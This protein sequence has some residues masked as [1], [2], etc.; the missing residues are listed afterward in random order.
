MLL[1]AGLL[2]GCEFLNDAFG[3]ADVF[4]AE[5]LEDAS[6]ETKDAA[7]P[8]EDETLS[9]PYK[10]FLHLNKIRANPV[11]Y[12]EACEVDLSYVEPRPAL[13]WNAT[14]A[15]VAQAKAE[16]MV[17]RNYFG[18][19]DPDGNGMNIKIAEAGYSLNP[20]WYSD[21]ATNYFESLYAGGVTGEQGIERLIR[22]IGHDPPGHRN[23]LLGIVDFWANCTDVGIGYAKGNA[24]NKFKA[25][26]SVLVVKHDY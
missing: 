7:A 2:T 8:E 25:Y 3:D 26:M 4:D 17:A 13:K 10:A 14:L 19:V 12:S 22:D 16:D 6:T 5:V 24:E 23:H 15:K 11:A 21:P 18:H 1:C 9:E 20:K